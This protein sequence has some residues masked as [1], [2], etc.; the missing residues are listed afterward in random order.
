MFT[1][2]IVFQLTADEGGADWV[3]RATIN[4]HSFNSVVTISREQTV[5]ILKLLAISGLCIT[6]TEEVFSEQLDIL[7]KV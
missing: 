4:G 1:F 3:S 6:S 2:V 7:C 5:K